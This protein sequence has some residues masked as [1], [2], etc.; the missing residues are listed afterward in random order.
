[1]LLF[2]DDKVIAVVEDT[3]TCYNQRASANRSCS[4]AEIL[5]HDENKHCE[6]IL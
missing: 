2:D 6:L 5:N 3:T 4:K 1:M